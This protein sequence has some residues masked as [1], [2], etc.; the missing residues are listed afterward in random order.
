MPKNL[1][2]Y[3]GNKVTFLKWENNGLLLAKK[4]N[5]QYAMENVRLGQ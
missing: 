3:L 5:M 2:D 4:L 1:Q